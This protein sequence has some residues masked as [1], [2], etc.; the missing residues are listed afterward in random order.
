MA[1]ATATAKTA[2]TTHSDSGV[3]TKP[4]AP[5]FKPVKLT[6]GD[7]TR[8]ANSQ[9]AVYALEFDGFVKN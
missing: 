5:A 4:E 7:D 1:N 9:A 6:K 2:D 8:T 3:E